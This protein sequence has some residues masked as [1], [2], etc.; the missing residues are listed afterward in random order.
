M[1]SLIETTV[2]FLALL[3]TTQAIFPLFFPP[4][5]A[6]STVVG[7]G[8]Q[9]LLYGAVMF[10][11]LF[12]W[13]EFLQA[14]GSLKA[15]SLLVLLALASTAWSQYHSMS[16]RRGL[17][18]ASSTIF[19]IYFGIRYTRTQQIRLLAF[20][21][22]VVEILSVAFALFL[23][24]YGLDHG[25]HG[26]AWQG[27]FYQKNEL[28]RMMVVAALVFLLASKAVPRIVRWSGFIGSLV[29]LFLS[30]SVTGVLVL[31][32]TIGCLPLIFLTRTKFTFAVPILIFTTMTAC[33]LGPVFIERRA[34]VLAL[35]H[36]AENLTGRT[37]IWQAVIPQIAARPILGYGYSAFWLRTSGASANVVAAIHFVPVHSHN[38]FLDLLLELGGV[39][40]V[41][42]LASYI[43]QWRV[44]VEAFRHS[45]SLL[46]L[47]AVVLLLM[48]L[49]YN[50]A[51]SPLLRENHIVWV[52]YATNAVNLVF[53][54]YSQPVFSQ[55]P[56]NHGFLPLD[57]YLQR[58]P[59]IGV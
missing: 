4:T 26:G 17:L 31:A 56:V 41:I 10:F 18:L 27:V 46:D 2:T 13:R 42:F 49:F 15:I 21:F 44:A 51:E 58:R 9:V 14:V 53:S 7:I 20:T 6:M 23:P 57:H 34:E 48:I 19:G 30:H 36:R 3:F 1:T 54:R 39:G 59:S 37:L 25:R 33:V 32:L 50:L 29:L 47:W 16:L 55:L 52:L 35:M 8:I 12:R 38:G 11:T 45:G 24:D 5:N 28:G 22:A 43:S 40:F